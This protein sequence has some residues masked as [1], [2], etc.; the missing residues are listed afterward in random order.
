MIP[1]TTGETMEP[2]MESVGN[3]GARAVEAQRVCSASSQQKNKRVKSIARANGNGNGNK[4]AIENKGVTTRPSTAESIAINSNEVSRQ[5]DN[6]NEW[7]RAG[8]PRAR[9]TPARENWDG[10]NSATMVP[11]GRHKQT[12]ALSPAA[13]VW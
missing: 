4:S 13:R 2:T 3:K 6:G 11:E 10:T 5:I 12:M 1:E 9:N 8:A 7:Q